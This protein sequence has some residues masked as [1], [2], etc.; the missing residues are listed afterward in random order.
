MTIEFF[1]GLTTACDH[2]L[3]STKAWSGNKESKTKV[4]AAILIVAIKFLI[5]FGEMFFPVEFGDRIS[6]QQQYP[7]F[8]DR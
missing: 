8:C 5:L 7:F 1:R 6:S 4:Y 2:R 3:K